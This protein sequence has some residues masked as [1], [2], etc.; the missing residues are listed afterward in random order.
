MSEL[1]RLKADL[2]ALKKTRPIAVKFV[3]QKNII[4]YLNYHDRA[5]DT[6]QAKIKEL[7]TPPDPFRYAKELIFN[8]RTNCNVKSDIG[9][10]CLHL[11][12]EVERLKAEIE[13]RPVVWCLKTSSGSHHTG[14]VNNTTILFHSMLDAAGY[15]KKHGYH[16]LKADTYTGKESQ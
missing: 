5:V 7:E 1:E 14:G 16:W 3:D 4:D 8:M 2:E 10:Y 6:V 9:A 13:N 11:E 12:D 15:A